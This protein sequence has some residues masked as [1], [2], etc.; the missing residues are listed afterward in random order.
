MGSAQKA[1][2][3]VIWSVI[4]NIVS[5]I[6]GFL[7]VPLL[8]GYFGK[9]EYGL[10][11]LAMSVNAYMGLLD[12]G[13]N[14]TNVR[15]FSNWLAKKN[16]EKVIKLMQTCNAFY[17]IIGCINAVVLIIVGVYSSEIFH[18]TESQDLI[19]KQMLWILAATAIINWYTSCFGQMINATENVAWIQKRTLITKILLVCSVAVTLVLKLSIL[20]YFILTILSSLLLI[21]LTVRKLRKE[22]PY[23]KL[24]PKFDNDIFKEILPYSLSIF[25]FG[26]F[27]F[28]FL[29]SR[30]I[31]LGMRGTVESITEY[32]VMNGLT[33][34]VTMVGS[35]F[36]NA[37][38]PASSRVVANNN[39]ESY[40]NI[41]YRGTHFITIILGFCSFGLMSISEDL[42]M[43]YVGN[44][45]LHL[46][47]WL[48]VWLVLLLYT[49]NSCIS[50]LILGGS[51]V[52]LLTYSCAVS[53]VVGILVGW[54]VV[55]YY[56][57]GGSIISLGAFYIVQL[58]FNYFYYWPKKLEINSFIIFKNTLFP[59]VIVGICLN[60]LIR[61]IPHSENHWLNIMMFGPLFA[62]MYSIA[63]YLMTKNEDRAFAMS[64]IKRK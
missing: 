51:D 24:T 37:L 22:A 23:I 3:G 47:R 2:S 38:L 53:A 11:A 61:L 14:S 6:Y 46:T 59:I 5:A 35:V 12:L 30:T 54:Y 42:L 20:V 39:K 9:S 26:I 29:N 43:V 31:I 55:P 52:K 62:A 44:D 19:L 50:S 48:N 63:V 10:I 28:L 64:L 18:V 27:Q 13:L 32:S 8:I 25:S 1:V 49:H 58:F 16:T 40:Y 33:G 60:Y 36:I 7:A 15:F 56:Q 21:P 4:V 41:A 34:L 17:G 45:F 57:A